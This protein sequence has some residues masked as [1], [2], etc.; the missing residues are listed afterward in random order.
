MLEGASIQRPSWQGVAPK[1]AA[2]AFIRL[3]GG[4]GLERARAPS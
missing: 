3:D 4:L 1:G 2:A